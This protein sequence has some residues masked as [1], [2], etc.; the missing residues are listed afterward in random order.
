MSYGLVISPEASAVIA[1][2]DDALN[3]LFVMACLDL[4]DDPHVMGRLSSTEGAFATRNYAVGG[5]GLIMFVVNDANRTITVT[6]VLW[7]G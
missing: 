5:L 6:D 7:L 3:E 4:Q 2:M 1:A